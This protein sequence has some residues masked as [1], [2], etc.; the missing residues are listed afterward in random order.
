M[1][2]CIRGRMTGCAAELGLDRVRWRCMHVCN[3]VRAGSVA[4]LEKRGSDRTPPKL[5]ITG[6]MVFSVY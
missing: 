6:T 4:A 5:S 1:W 2:S 3:D